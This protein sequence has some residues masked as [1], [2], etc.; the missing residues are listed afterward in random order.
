MPWPQ[1]FVLGSGTALPSA[2]RDNTSLA[3]DTP[4]GLWLIDCGGSVYHK[5][6]HLGL[7][8]LRLQGVF[9]THN[10]LDHVY[11]LPALLFHL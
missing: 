5:L 9:L 10:H 11:G 1:L 4:E 3:V 7:D 8:P 6:L 2:E